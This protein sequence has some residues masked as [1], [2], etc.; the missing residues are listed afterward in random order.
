MSD[1]ILDYPQLINGI[2]ILFSFFV[3]YKFGTSLTNSS[4]SSSEST[5]KPQ[6]KTQPDPGNE[7][8]IIRDLNRKCLLIKNLLF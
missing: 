2:A 6:A 5:S 4:S 1:N 3:G 8:N 7:V